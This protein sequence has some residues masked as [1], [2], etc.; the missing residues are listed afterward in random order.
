MQSEIQ[1]CLKYMAFI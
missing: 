1:A